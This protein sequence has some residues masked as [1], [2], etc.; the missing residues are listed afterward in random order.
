MRLGNGMNEVLNIK[1]RIFLIKK[2]RN[3]KN[4]K[5]NCVFLCN[6]TSNEFNGCEFLWVSENT[7]SSNNVG[8]ESF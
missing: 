6:N 7:N 1:I 5:S 4:N 3:K 2:E 8:E